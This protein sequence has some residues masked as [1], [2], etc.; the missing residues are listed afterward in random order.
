MAELEGSFDKTA[1]VAV[2]EFTVLEVG[3]A[4]AGTVAGSATVTGAVMSVMVEVANTL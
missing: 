1:C 2:A 3:S 4:D